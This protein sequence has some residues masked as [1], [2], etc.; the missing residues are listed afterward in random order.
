MDLSVVIAI[1]LFSTVCLRVA[2]VLGIVWL[3]VPMRAQCPRCSDSTFPLV[4]PRPMRVLRLQRRWCLGCGWT[5][6]SKSVQRAPDRRP[7]RIGVEKPRRVKEEGRWKA[8]WD[9]DDQWSAV[10]D[11]EWR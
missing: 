10:G 8:R 3:L 7:D 1:V 11:E 9:D 2:L 6:V 5:G 4:S